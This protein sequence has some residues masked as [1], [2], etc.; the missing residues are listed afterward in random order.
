MGLMERFRQAS[1]AWA[2]TI[3][4]FQPTYLLK[5]PGLKDVGVL[6]QRNGGGTA[7][8]KTR[9]GSFKIRLA[10]SQERS[11]EAS[12]LV[13]RRYSAAG[14]VVVGPGTHH[15][16]PEQITLLSYRGDKVVGTLTLG[17]DIGGGLYADEL[18]KGEIDG[19]RAQG[20]K[21]AEITKLAIDS[22]HAS[23]RVFASMIHIAYIY[24]RKLWRYTDVVIEVNPS[25]V[26]FYKKLLGFKELGPERYCPRV[27]A[28]AVLLW[29][30]GIQ[31]DQRIEEVGGQT[32]LAKQDKSLY[33]YFFSKAE[34]VGITRRLLQSEQQ[35]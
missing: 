16:C 22:K 18:Y 10:H 20:R 11:K 15:V 3:V 6:P 2:N 19:L 27:D 9:E 7:V 31:V 13:K 33:P 12:V 34:E 30:E 17:M 26:S 28:P 1:R 25:H 14:Y 29:I 4:A 23:K 24:C 35:T 32:D 21:V 8:E 5:D